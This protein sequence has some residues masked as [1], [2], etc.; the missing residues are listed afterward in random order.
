MPRIPDP[1]LRALFEHPDLSLAAKG[2]LAVILTRPSAQGSAPSTY[3]APPA[4]P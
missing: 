2:A 1:A 3:S 4:T